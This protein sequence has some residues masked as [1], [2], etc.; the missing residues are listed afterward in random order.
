MENN[1][2]STLE[3]VRKKLQGQQKTVK[4]GKKEVIPNTSQESKL[5]SYLKECNEEDFVC[6]NVAYID[7]DIHDI[8]TRLKKKTGMKIGHFLSFL[9]KDFFEKHKGEINEIL[10]SN[11]YLK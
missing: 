9:A 3:D 11:K 5:L 6:K 8:A 4:S 2:K 10:N 7:E 1:K